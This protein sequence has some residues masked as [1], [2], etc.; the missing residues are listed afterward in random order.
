M[1]EE[2]IIELE[3]R[4]WQLQSYSRT[5]KMDPSTLLP[6]V[7]PPLPDSIFQGFF[8]AF[9][10]N[11]DGHIDFKEMACGISAAARGP[12][13]ERQKFCFKVFDQDKDGLLS[14]VEVEKMICVMKSVLMETMSETN[15]KDEIVLAV[16]KDNAVYIEEITN[17]ANNG[18][19]GGGDNSGM[20]LEEYLVWSLSNPLPEQFLTLIYQVCQIVFGLKPLDPAEE[21]EVVT[22]WLT[23]EERRGFQTGQIWYV[24]SMDWWNAW[25]QYANP[26]PPPVM[27]NSD[28]GLSSM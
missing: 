3:K 20:T 9:D 25:G 5:G 14:L 28:S 15:P 1:E 21:F 19:S 27:S 4:Y 2:D 26:N 7:S 10:E 17:N 16:T 8:D 22:S 6:L 24:I 23:R 18:I 11:R 13:I 12:P